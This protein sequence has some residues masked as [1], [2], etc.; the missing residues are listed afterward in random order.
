[1]ED[2]LEKEII[3]TGQAPTALGP[4]SQ[5][6]KAGDLLFISGQLGIDP[7]SGT[8]IESDIGNETRLVLENIKAILEASGSSLDKVV[9]TTVFVSDMNNFEKMNEI[10]GQ[11]F[12]K[13]PPARATVEVGK[14]P[15]HA[16]VE[17]EAIAV[18]E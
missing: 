7:N 17:I 16:R 3:D 12:A 8:L 14:L 11:Y 9:K 13:S 18:C 1:M 5:A 4:Y 2:T 6:I 15:K 10:Y